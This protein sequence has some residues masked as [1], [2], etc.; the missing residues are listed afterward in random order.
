MLPAAYVTRDYPQMQP[1]ENLP[2][3]EEILN[4]ISSIIC[5]LQPHQVCGVVVYYIFGLIFNIIS[6][7]FM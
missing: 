5:D 7:Y 4:N 3:I 6:A 2:F 1:N